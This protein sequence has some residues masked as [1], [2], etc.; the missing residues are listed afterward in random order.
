MDELWLVGMVTGTDSRSVAS[1]H[2][3]YGKEI[4]VLQVHRML[5][6]SRTVVRGAEADSSAF[7]FR[8]P[9]N[10]V[11]AILSHADSLNSSEDGI[12]YRSLLSNHAIA[13]THEP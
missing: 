5:A 4:H 7:R 2:T 9:E 1:R 10:L 8:F 3:Y 6:S 12:D 13:W 11:G